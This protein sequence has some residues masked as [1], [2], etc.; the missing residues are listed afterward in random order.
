VI[1]RLGIMSKTSARLSPI[2]ILPTHYD[3]VYDTIDFVNFTFSGH[4]SIHGTALSSDCRSIKLHALSLQLTSAS[5]SLMSA[6]SSGSD[7][8]LVLATAHEFRY[9]LRNQTCDVVFSDDTVIAPGQNYCLICAFCGILNDQMRGLYRSAYMRSDNGV[10]RYMATTQFEPTDARRAFPCLDE[11]ALKATFTLTVHNIPAALQCISNTP[12]AAT[13]TTSTA[14]TSSGTTPTKTVVFQTT[15]KM[16]TYLLAMV[17]GEFDGISQTSRSIVTT[18][19][20][21]KGKAAQGKFCLDVAVKC[22][23]YYQDLFVGIPYPLTKSDLLAIPDFAAGAMENWGCVTY[24]EAKILVQ[25]GIT[26]VGTVRGVAR[27]ICH[28]LAH[29]WFGNLVTMEYWT[30]VCLCACFVTVV[31]FWN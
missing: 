24:R 15:P 25:P 11:P 1:D 29:Q 31:C 23:D 16:S 21:A 7:K 12:V 13:Y 28:E 10:R 14:T 9:H 8:H 20:T 26:S 19:Y 17:I 4:V 5:L 22:L 18:V 30:Q 2:V 3:L 6:G 27:T